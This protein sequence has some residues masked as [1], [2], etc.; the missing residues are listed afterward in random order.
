MRIGVLSD[1]HLRTGQPLPR[2]LWDNLQ[3]V[4]LILHAGDVVSPSVLGDLSYMAPVRAV[5]GNCDSLELDYLPVS[6]LVICDGLRIG[7]THGYRG[8]G[9]ST[10][11]RA[12]NTFVQ[13]KVDAIVFGHSHSP[14]QEWRNGILLFNP[15]SA[16]DKRREPQCSFGFLEIAQGEIRP[17]HCY[18]G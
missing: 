9:T 4:D 3:G 15:G 6:D 10:P 13:E 17:S 16:T 14:Y 7:L 11:D 1:T 12:Y 18:Y 2:Y 5:K 8:T